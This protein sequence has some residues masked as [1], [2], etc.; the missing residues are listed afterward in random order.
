MADELDRVS[1]LIKLSNFD[2][3]LAKSSVSTKSS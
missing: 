2:L 1:S 3:P